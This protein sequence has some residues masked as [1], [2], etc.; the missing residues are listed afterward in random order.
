EAGG[1]GLYGDHRF[2]PHL[3]ALDGLNHLRAEKET[4]KVRPG[5][6]QKQAGN[7]AEDEQQQRGIDQPQVAA[8]D[9]WPGESVKMDDPARTRFLSGIDGIVSAGKQKVQ[10]TRVRSAARVFA[11]S[12]KIGRSLPVKQPQFLKLKPGQRAKTLLAALVE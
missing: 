1:Q 2:C 3:V 8:E 5:G 9:S 11:Q 6:G 10:R 4:H 12:G 7:T